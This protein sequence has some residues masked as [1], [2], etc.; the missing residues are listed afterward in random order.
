MAAE[1][2]TVG[3]LSFVHRIAVG[4]WFVLWQVP[5]V[6]PSF[7]AEMIPYS[8]SLPL[9]LGLAPALSTVHLVPRLLVRGPF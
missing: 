4:G 3:F 1:C 6:G 2:T 7:W 9:W 8:T 5:F